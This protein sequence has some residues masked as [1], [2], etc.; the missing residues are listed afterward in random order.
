[1]QMAKANELR[2]AWA[3]KGNP[4]CEHPSLDKEYHLGSDT[5]DVVCASCGECWSRDDPTR[6]DRNR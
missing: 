6:P 2:E 4:P 5:G 1:M 3:A